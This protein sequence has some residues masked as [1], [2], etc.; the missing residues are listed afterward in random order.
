LL[1]V[2]RRSQP[3]QLFAAGAT[4]IALLLVSGCRATSSRQAAAPPESSGAGSR[5]HA[6]PR[7]WPEQKIIEAHAHYAAAVVHEMDNEPEAALREYYLAAYN[8]PDNETLVLE[9]S[10]RF[11]QQKQPEK[12]L[13][14]LARAADR[15][16]AP[17]AI[18]AQL[19]LVYQQLGR[20]DQA[21]AA[22]RAAINRAP[23]A[24]EGYRNLC[25][26]YLQKKQPQEALKILEGLPRQSNTNVEFYLGLG[27]LYARISLSDGPQKDAARAAGVA[28]LDRAEQLKPAG[29]ALRLRLADALNLLGESSRA[30]ALYLDLLKSLPD[31]P[32]L[33]EQIH[34]KLAEVYLRS[35]DPEQ[36]MKQIE[37]IV[38]DQPTNP[39]AYYLLGTIAFEAKKFPEATDYFRK[40]ILMRPDLEAAYYHL[41][42]AQIAQNKTSDSLATLDK[43]RQ[44]FPAG[45]LLEFWT[46]MAF[47][48]DKAYKQA[49]EHYTAA[50]LRAK[51]SE[52]ER[53]D[54]S[55]YFQLG[56]AC[57]RSGDLAQAEKYFEKCLKLAPGFAEAMNYMGYMWAEKGVKL[58]QAKVLIE[59]ALKIEPKNAAYLDSLG[60]VLFKLNH[61]KDALGYILKA[62]EL[63]EQPDATEYDHLGDIYAAL[64]QLDKARE[65]WKKS[66]A[67]EANDEVKKKLEK[68]G[69]K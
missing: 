53:L 50:E 66:L 11:L 21:V 2:P 1:V 60:W 69:G 68:S 36:A 49:V 26:V 6:G 18:F 42:A 28:A 23:G 55:F 19:G 38:R 54:E 62:I 52:P 17:A 14:I 51:A 27:E 57:E 64:K 3:R 63:T 41:A 43:A 9:T 31:V 15:P 48:H 47:S 34:A 12:A 59:K 13:E 44:K 30:I 67:I 25:L 58:D 61:P 37:A 33:R 20:I 10:A 4:A 32:L 22:D 46:G 65:A 7:Q 40:A 16:N 45:F 29:S 24:F 5:A 56:A 35:K 8:D 39:Q